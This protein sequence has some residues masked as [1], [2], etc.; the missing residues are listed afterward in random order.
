MARETRQQREARERQEYEERL[1]QERATYLPRLVA[2][3]ERACKANFELEVC[4]GK[5]VV[6]DRDE[7]RAEEHALF[8]EHN[9]VAEKHL[10]SLETD[11][12]VKEDEL[13]EAERKRQ[14]KET[15]LS[16]LS[17]EEREALGL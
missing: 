5:F 10:W 12:Q 3:L 11:V 15:A 6:Y 8:A 14:L 16:K 7:R 13:Q 2:L 4:D 9:E 1:A 17:H